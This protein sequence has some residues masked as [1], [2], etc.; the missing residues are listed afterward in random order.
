[1]LTSPQS[2]RDTVFGSSS[3]SINAPNAPDADVP[4]HPNA[5]GYVAYA[6][7]VSATL[8]GAWIGKQQQHFA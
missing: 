4:F 5:N 6:D 8:P 2:L 7:A 3:T 1:M